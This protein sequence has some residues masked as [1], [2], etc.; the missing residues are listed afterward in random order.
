MTHR[1][2]Y[3]ALIG[4]PNVGKSSVMNA[5]IGEEVAIV[6]PM[7]QTTRQR[8][9][10]IA[11]TPESQVIFLDTPGVHLSDRAINQAMVATTEAVLREADGRV[12][13]VDASQ[14]A[15]SVRLPPAFLSHRWTCIV[16]NKIDLLSERV[17]TQLQQQLGREFATMISP[18]SAVR[19]DGID[20]LRHHLVAALP[21]GPPLFPTDIYTEHSVR[22][23]VAEWIRKA[24]IEHLAE[25][26]PHAIAV[27]I[28]AFHE[29]APCT[30]I[31]A[32]IIVERESQKGMVIGRGGRMIR[33]IGTT[34]RQYM[35]ACVGTHVYLGLRVRVERQWRTRPEQLR[36]FGFIR[37]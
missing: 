26:L 9:A 15:S 31:E 6:T 14:V 1:C 24:V 19:G 29:D 34:A 13:V 22:F 10:G 20:S 7:P 35:T 32:T 2:G 5:L 3:V 36:R 37:S 33:A 16:L 18:V 17:C 30:R 28:E 12:L 23:L 21:E 8:I 11:S 27:E 4:L 25:E